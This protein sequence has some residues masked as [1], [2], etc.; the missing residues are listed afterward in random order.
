MQKFIPCYED[1]HNNSVFV[2][3]MRY[4]KVHNSTSFCHTPFLD[5][6]YPKIFVVILTTKLE[7]GL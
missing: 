6:F 5:V 3:K 4:A 7:L 2:Y 1:V